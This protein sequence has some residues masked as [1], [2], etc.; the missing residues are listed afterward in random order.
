MTQVVDK[1]T[2]EITYLSYL[3]MWDQ[4]VGFVPSFL[5]AEIV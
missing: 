1:L 4:E 5:F 2:E 3:A